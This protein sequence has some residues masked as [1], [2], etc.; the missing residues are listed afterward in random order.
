MN[1]LIYQQPALLSEN[2]QLHQRRALRSVG[3]PEND[4][5]TVSGALVS[6]VFMNHIP[7]RVECIVALFVGAIFPTPQSLQKSNELRLI[8]I[9]LVDTIIHD[10]S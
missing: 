7:Y 5:H 2:Q 4:F 1:H 6:F 3:G 10:H 8:K 9:N